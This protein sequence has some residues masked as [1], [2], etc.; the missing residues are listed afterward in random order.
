MGQ[1]AEV[2]KRE[3]RVGF[4]GRLFLSFLK[5]GMTA[6]GGPAMVAYIRELA[7]RRNGWLSDDSFKHGVAVCQSIPGATAMQVAAYVGL[8]AGGGWGAA[9]TYVGFGLPAF[10]LMVALSAAYGRA[11]NLA[12]VVSGF[13]GLQ[14]IVVALVANATLSFGK[15]SL[16]DWRDG[17]LALGAAAFLVAH[18]SP[19]I[20]ILASALLGLVVYVHIKPVAG[21]SEAPVQTGGVL[22]NLKTPL[23][24]V[25]LLASGLLF[26]YS[27]DRHLFDL[28]TLMIKVD[29][30]AFG[31]GYAS[32]PI[33]LHEVVDVRHWMDS[34]VFMDGIALG[35]VTPGPIVITAT[36]VGFLLT[37]LVGA[38]VGTISVFTPS[39]IILT[40]AVP[41]FDRFRSNVYF[42]RALRGA[43][44]SFVGLLLAVTIQFALAVHWGVYEALIAG[45]AFLAFYR[46]IDIF[47]V[48][49]VGAVV[50]ALIL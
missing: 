43:L 14:V 15:S 4:T 44:V 5:L 26:L 34:K 45:G 28:S 50:S 7:V 38:V 29:L 47:W 20:A 41:Y 36:F 40:A 39:L 22:D 24:L 25:A 3:G 18:G 2:R 19:V 46:K 27:F 21:S 49:I 32:V 1:A 17:L 30:F 11:H 33:M 23:V 16:K 12:M 31:G 6:F 37:G 8:R 42:Q 13:K 48:V 35:Q 9:A 10:F